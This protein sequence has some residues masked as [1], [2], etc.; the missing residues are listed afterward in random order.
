M[1]EINERAAEL[2]AERNRVVIVTMPEKENLTPPTEDE[3]AA[4]LAGVQQKDI[5]PYVDEVIDAPL[6]AEVP[7]PVTIKAERE[8]PEVGVT[9]ITLETASAW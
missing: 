6:I 1:A 5:A 4:I 3:L 2:L 8:I 9:E 7:K